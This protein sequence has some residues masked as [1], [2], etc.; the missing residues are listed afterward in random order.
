MSLWRQPTPYQ[1]RNSLPLP[2]AL[3]VI[4][5]KIA[6]TILSALSVSAQSQLLPANAIS[7]DLSVS[8]HARRTIW[9]FSRNSGSTKSTLQFCNALHACI[10]RSL[11]AIAFSRTHEDAGLKVLTAHRESIRKVDALGFGGSVQ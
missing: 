11:C 10:L 6:S 7:A 1:L 9:R 2:E 4:S 8:A 3:R 5:E